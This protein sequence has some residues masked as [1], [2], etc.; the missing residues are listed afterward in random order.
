M[1][2]YTTITKVG[3]DQFVKYRNVSNLIRFT[4][5]LDNK[6]PTW[7]YFNVYDKKSKK[8]VASFTKENRPFSPKI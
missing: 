2:L 6:F 1:A 3:V 8:Q 4:H 5:F 7:R